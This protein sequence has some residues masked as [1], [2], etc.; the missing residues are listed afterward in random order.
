[1][2]KYTSNIGVKN[3]VSAWAH[4]ELNRKF[5]FSEHGKAYT[6]RRL[7]QSAIEFGEII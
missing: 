6:Y 1:M 3:L 2:K 5:L 7:K 4:S